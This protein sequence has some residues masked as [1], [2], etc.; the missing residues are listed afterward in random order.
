[1]RLFFSLCAFFWFCSTVEEQPQPPVPHDLFPLMMKPP[2]MTS[3][4]QPFISDFHTG[5]RQISVK[6]AKNFRRW[7]SGLFS[8][9]GDG[10]VAAV[11]FF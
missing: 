3:I 11:R 8:G 4:I 9:E 5:R 2:P 1:M 7:V 6:D 10:A